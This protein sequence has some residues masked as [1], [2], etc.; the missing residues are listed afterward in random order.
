[1]NIREFKYQEKINKK[2]LLASRGVFLSKREDGVFSIFLF[3]MV[4]FYVEMFYDNEEEEI[5]YIRAFQS[6]N[7][8]NPYLEQIDISEIQQ[9]LSTT[10]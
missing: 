2:K 1:M 5:G 10:N 6:V 8:L 3:Q 7:E 9:V 4:N